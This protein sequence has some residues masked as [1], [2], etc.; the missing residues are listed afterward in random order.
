MLRSVTKFRTPFV[1]SE[2]N[3]LLGWCRPKST[4]DVEHPVGNQ[5]PS[6]EESSRTAKERAEP[7]GIADQSNPSQQRAEP[8]PVA[9][10][11]SAALGGTMGVVVVEE[12]GVENPATGAPAAEGAATEEEADVEE[13]IHP[14]EERVAPQCV[15]V[16]RKRGNEWVFYEEDHSDRAVCKLH[17]TVEDLIG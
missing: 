13:I 2:C 12:S 1:I 16:A 4:E 15:R 6:T 7:S 14:E 3:S 8:T 9:E 17:R 5:P 10:E 11:P